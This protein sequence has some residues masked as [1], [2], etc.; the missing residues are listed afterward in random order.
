[1]LLPVHML[2]SWIPWTPICLRLSGEAP[3]RLTSSL[4]S[5]GARSGVREPRRVTV[6]VN[7]ASVTPIQ[8]MDSS[9]F[10]L[11]LRLMVVL[12]NVPHRRGAEK[13]VRI[14]P[15]Q[16]RAKTKLVHPGLE[17]LEP[18]SDKSRMAALEHIA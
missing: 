2:G 10:D 3:H 11:F 5:A 18:I 7:R 14:W 17:S 8:L 12:Y 9:G 13:D 6:G 15:R 16:R 1:M 4:R